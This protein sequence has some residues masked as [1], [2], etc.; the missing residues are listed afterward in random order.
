MATCALCHTY[1]RVGISTPDRVQHVIEN[2][3]NDYVYIPGDVICG[4]CTRKCDR[5]NLASIIRSHRYLKYCACCKSHQRSAI[6]SKLGVIAFMGRFTGTSDYVHEIG[7]T[8]C[9]NCAPLA[10]ETKTCMVCKTDGKVISGT[11]EELIVDGVL[12]KRGT[13]MCRQCKY[14]GSLPGKSCRVCGDNST[15]R[16][17]TTERVINSVTIRVGDY[18]CSSCSQRQF[19]LDRKKRALEDDTLPTGRQRIA[20]EN[21]A[22]PVL[23]PD[24]TLEQIWQDM[25]KEWVTQLDQ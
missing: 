10:V 19:H 21:D 3:R 16:K 8:I 12:Q 11:R 6:V 22:R 1:R 5:L 13:P 23:S 4:P 20:V 17:S 24:S 14:Q 18:S 2:L 25:E 7:H 15:L 9:K